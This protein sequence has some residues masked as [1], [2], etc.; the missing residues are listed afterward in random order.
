MASREA[1]VRHLVVMVRACY[2]NERLDSKKLTNLDSNW[3]R[4]RSQFSADSLRFYFYNC[5]IKLR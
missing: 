4:V 5:I 1:S 3:S 2:I